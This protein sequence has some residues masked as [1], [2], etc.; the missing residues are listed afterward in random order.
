MGDKTG[1]PPFLCLVQKQANRLI[2]TG[3]HGGTTGRTR[4]TVDVIPAEP[5]VQGEK[6]RLRSTKKPY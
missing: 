1:Y 3:G 6:G 2:V 5:T 4:G